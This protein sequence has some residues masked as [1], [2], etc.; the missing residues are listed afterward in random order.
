MWKVKNYTNEHIYEVETNLTDVENKFM[1][2]KGEQWGE[3]YLKSLELAYKYYCIEKE[4]TNKDLLCIT[5]N[6]TQYSVITFMGK[7]SEKEQIHVYI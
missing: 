6:P 4:I 1:V 2:I 3:G 7:E 5:G